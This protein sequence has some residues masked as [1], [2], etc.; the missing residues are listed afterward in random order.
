MSWA[1]D[2][3]GA[4]C[5]VPKRGVIPGGLVPSYP[6]DRTNAAAEHA[7]RVRIRLHVGQ[8]CCESDL[9]GRKVFSALYRN[10]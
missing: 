9:Q 8:T 2:G 5:D 3:I 7:R 6:L 10:L 4:R 1:D